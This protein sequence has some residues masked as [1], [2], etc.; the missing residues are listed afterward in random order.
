MR[1]RGSQPQD[2]YQHRETELKEREQALRLREIEAELAQKREV[3]IEP[4]TETVRMQS[5]ETPLSRWRRKLSVAAK[6]FVILVIAIAGITLGKWIAMAVVIGSI[7]WLT[8]KAFF[9][10]DSPRE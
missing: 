3:E 2:D 4:A 7:G 6:L 1:S 10:G 5:R 9:D 8:Y